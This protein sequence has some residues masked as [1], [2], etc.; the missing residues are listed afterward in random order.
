SLRQLAA[1]LSETNRRKTEFLATLAHEL[2]NPLAPMRTGL[3][4]LRM[5]SRHGQ[6]GQSGQGGER[7]LD[8]MDR[9]LRQMVHLIDDLMDVSRINSG[10]IEL[11]KER[12]ELRDA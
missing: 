3:D 2:R 9:Q 1:D 4:L 8:M 6:S 5:S 7:V 12:I 10:K 11:K